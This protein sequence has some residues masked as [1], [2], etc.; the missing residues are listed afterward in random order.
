VAENVMY[1]GVSQCYALN[2]NQQKKNMKM[3]SA[4]ATVNSILVFAYFKQANNAIPMSG[5][6]AKCS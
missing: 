5:K 3:V 1:G 4:L 6:W 2:F